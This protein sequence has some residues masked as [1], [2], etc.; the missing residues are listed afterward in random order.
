[1]NQPHWKPSKQRAWAGQENKTAKGLK[2]GSDWIGTYALVASP[3]QKPKTAAADNSSG[4]GK[5]DRWFLLAS[6]ELGPGGTK[7]KRREIP[8][9]RKTQAE[10]GKRAGSL[11]TA[12]I[13]I[14]SAGF[15]LHERENNAVGM[16]THE[17]DRTGA[18]GT[19]PTG[20]IKTWSPP[21]SARGQTKPDRADLRSSSAN[22]ALK[23]KTSQAAMEKPS[24]KTGHTLCSWAGK[25]CGGKIL[26]GPDLLSSQKR[27]SGRN[28][29]GDTEPNL[30]GEQV[31]A[32]WHGK[33]KNSGQ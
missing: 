13:E 14:S 15:L 4:N 24:L 17:N 1:V 26:R 22:T 27:S 16:P 18:G 7:I 10:K 32:R 3:A 21:L 5:A 6:E 12:K 30:G 29:E 25:G 28:D 2:A 11:L 19:I 8:S 9:R 23:M 20:K 33:M 31:R